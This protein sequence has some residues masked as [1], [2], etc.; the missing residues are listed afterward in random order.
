MTEI[1]VEWEHLQ[2]RRAKLVV[3]DDATS[4]QWT[5]LADKLAHTGRAGRMDEILFEAIGN[6]SWS[7]PDGRFGGRVR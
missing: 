3:P 1:I 6:V 5:D 2:R 7:A 4:E